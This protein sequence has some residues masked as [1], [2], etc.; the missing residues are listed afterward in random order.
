[1]NNRISYSQFSMWS[2]C[3]QRWKLNYVD[4]LKHFSGNIHTVFGSAMHTVLQTYLTTFYS[5]TITEA[6]S[7]DLNDMLFTE[8]KNE[9]IESKKN[10][11]DDPCT[12]EDLQSF[13]K[14]GV[15]LLD[16]FKKNKSMY[17][18]KRGYELL[19]IEIEL[20]Y[21]LGEGL[22]F[23]GFMDVV[24][25]DTVRDRIKI[26]D[27]KTSTK[28]WNKWMKTDK[29]KTD[30]LL[31]YKQFYSKE[32]DVPTDKIDIEYFILKRKLYE[33]VDFPQRKVQL[34]TPANGK[35]SLN[36]VLYRLKEF[37]DSCFDKQGNYLLKEYNTN[38]SKKTCRFCEF[39]QTE[40][41]DKGIK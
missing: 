26:I 5:K 14:D 6:D 41:C 33:N 35:P 34:F 4:K 22:N 32:F 19:G 12:K 38:E 24:I 9:F 25:K 1:M 2:Q 21:N 10:S 17:F 18:S 40:Y 29:Q 16:W 37:V 20:N 15:S 3:P 39:N 30:Q 11:E 27:L 8:L 7:L 13:Y 23:I 28:G 31:L 36:K